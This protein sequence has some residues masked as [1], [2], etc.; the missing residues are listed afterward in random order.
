[1]PDKREIRGPIRVGIVGLGNWARYGPP[2]LPPNHTSSRYTWMDCRRNAKR[3]FH[4]FAV[5]SGRM[6]TQ[7]RRIPMS[8]GAGVLEAVGE[9]VENLAVGDHV[10]SCFFPLWQ[11]G[12][13]AIADF[14]TTPGDG[15]DGHAREGVVRLT[16]WFAHAPKGYTHVEAA[17]LTTFSRSIHAV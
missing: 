6:P 8:D 16:S 2:R 17:T 9:G 5:V 7:D 13:A 12:P 11:G 1:M 10:V 15:V 4:D 14:S 3:L